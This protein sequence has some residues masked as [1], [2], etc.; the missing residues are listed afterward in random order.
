M[1]LASPASPSRRR[2]CSLAL[3]LLLF[4]VSAGAV[5]ACGDG[6]PGVAPGGEDAGDAG[7]A[8]T[9]PDTP[10]GDASTDVDAGAALAT[11]DPKSW[12]GARL[13]REV[14]HGGG[15][16]LLQ[17][18]VDT[19]REDTR[20][21]FRPAEDGALRCLPHLNLAVQYLDDQCSEAQMVGVVPMSAPPG[22]ALKTELVAERGTECESRMS[23]YELGSAIATAGAGGSGVPPRWE[24]NADGS[25]VPA[26]ALQVGSSIHRTATKLAATAFVKG[27]RSP[28]P[29]GGRLARE[30][31]VAEDGAGYAV[32]LWDSQLAAR[33]SVWT[34]VGGTE[35]C[36]PGEHVNAGVF[37]DSEC[38]TVV[39]WK[40]SCGGAPAFIVRR[41]GQPPTYGNELYSVGAPH[42]GG[43]FQKAGNSCLQLPQPQ[44]ELFS[45]ALVPNDDIAA[46]SRIWEGSGRIHRGLLVAGGVKL[47]T[48]EEPLLPGSSVF[49]TETVFDEDLGTTCRLTMWKDDVKCLPAEI[50]ASKAFADAACTELVLLADAAPGT[51]APTFA[52]IGFDDD[53]AF[54]RVGASRVVP[55]IYQLDSE[56]M[57]EAVPAGPDGTTV[58]DLTGPTPMTAFL[59]FVREIE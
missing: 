54:Y 30:G 44:V 17:S 24:R 23:V 20:C 37:G 40:D 34:D 13:K 2:A 10:E 26:G 47:A 7:P 57:C 58:R 11:R 49:P 35:R 51:P 6:D 15:T 9:P 19:G 33:C 38:T 31:I 1:V 52:Q 39:A 4:G 36:M 14:W 18:F 45:T 29:G 48:R 43:A 25:C 3:L 53:A 8:T 5:T 16:S 55:A 50:Y 27:T 56:G 59:T 12:S 28:M 32:G 46:V 21:A 22:L 41:A 42:E